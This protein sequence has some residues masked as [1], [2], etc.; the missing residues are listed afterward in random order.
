[1]RIF[2]FFLSGMSLT[3][4]SFSLSAQKLPDVQ[5]SAVWLSKPLKIDGKPDSGIVDLKA[6]NKS[7]SL[8]Y[9]IGN[10]AENLFLTI[11][12]ADAANNT[13]IMMG[14][15]TLKINPSGNKK[16]KNG[17][18]VTFPVINA[19]AR[20]LRSQRGSWQGNRSTGATPE[21]RQKA[22]SMMAAMRQQQIAE[23]K[24]IGVSGFKEIAD[25]TISI[26]NEY[27]IKAAV[28]FDQ[29]GSFIYELA[30]PL[31][32]LNMLSGNQGFIYNI[33]VN[34][35]PLRSSA[36]FAGRSGDGGM[37]GGLRRGG[38][39]GGFEGRGGGYRGA[40]DGGR[41]GFDPAILE[42]TDFWAKYT[43]AKK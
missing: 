35:R 19:G 24:E 12:S 15:I 27:G 38:S 37:R 7:T 29:Q 39:G 42:P 14:G 28:N 31:K 9:T 6:Y 22:D 36:A 43:L 13:K 10:D 1:M 8:F 2:Y 17:Y 23:F 32:Q 40:A 11:K 34:G 3:F 4:L 25:S 16:D 26:Y 20:S 5:E 41:G 21:S 18:T 30:I 33:R